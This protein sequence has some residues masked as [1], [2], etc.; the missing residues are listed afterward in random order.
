MSFLTRGRD[1]SALDAENIRVINLMGIQSDYRIDLAADLFQGVEGRYLCYIPDGTTVACVVEVA[2]Q[3]PEQSGNTRFI[4]LNP[5][6]VLDLWPASFSRVFVRVLALWSGGSLSYGATPRF[7]GRLLV[8]DH[9]ILEI[10]GANP[11][12]ALFVR[13]PVSSGGVLPYL[14]GVLSNVPGSSGRFQYAVAISAGPDGNVYRS[15]FKVKNTGNGILW[16]GKAGLTNGSDAVSLARCYP[17]AEGE[18]VDVIVGMEPRSSRQYDTAGPLSNTGLNIDS[19]T[20]YSD[21][22]T[23]AYAFIRRDYI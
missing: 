4:P 2:F 5:G 9:P 1:L 11:S 23:A 19:L 3:N 16:I 7:L 6:S 20:L 17:L 22:A 21:S 10:L 12:E 13:Q 8:A 15:D 14:N 18:T